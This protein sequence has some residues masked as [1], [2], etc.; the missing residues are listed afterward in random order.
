MKKLLMQFS[1][2]VLSKG[3]MK[4]VKGG[5]GDGGCCTV[6]CFLGDTEL[7]SADISSCSESGRYCK[8]TY[9]E[10]DRAGCSCA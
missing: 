5:Y 3:Q 8:L 10:A 6:T 4:G 1:D 2:N 9:P 7:G